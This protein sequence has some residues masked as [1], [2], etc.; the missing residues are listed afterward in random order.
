MAMESSGKGYD[1]TDNPQEMI[2]LA[3]ERTTS[4]YTLF[5]ATEIIN[6]SIQ[7]EHYNTHRRR[8]QMRKRGHPISKPEELNYLYGNAEIEYDGFLINYRDFVQPSM[9]GIEAVK[10]LDTRLTPSFLSEL[11]QPDLLKYASLASI[12]VAGSHIYPDANG[13]TAV[14]LAD[15]ILTKYLGKN[16][17]LEKLAI[18]EKNYSLGFAL[19]DGGISMLPGEYNPLNIIDKLK[20]KGKRYKE[21]FTPMPGGI[22]FNYKKEE[23][24]AYLKDHTASIIKYIDTFDPNKNIPD[25][26][27]LKIQVEKLANIYAKCLD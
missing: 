17:D 19:R 26:V 7:G 9:Y 20:Q 2:S 4:K 5:H 14:G 6:R 12:V 23:I 1:I 13:R 27:L 16:I 21:V 18:F 24:A 25:Q 22:I 8:N 10:H 3:A 15:Y 11:S